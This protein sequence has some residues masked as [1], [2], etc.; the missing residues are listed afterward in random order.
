MDGAALLADISGFTP[1]TEALVQALRPAIAL[2]LRFE[3]IEYEADSAAGQLDV[4][5]RWV[6]EVLARYEGALLQL[7]I[8][9][10][11]R[12]RGS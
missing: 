1:L 2:F 7:T 3:G 8:G 5:V 6:Q 4:Y 9:D 11:W 12:S 10:K